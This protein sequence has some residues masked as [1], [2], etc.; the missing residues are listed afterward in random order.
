MAL[1][2]NE[3]RDLMWI[4]V[5]DFLAPHLREQ[6]IQNARNGAIATFAVLKDGKWYERGS[7]GWW[8]C[9]ADEKNKEE[10]YN[11]FSS[12]IDSL[13]DDTLLTIVDCHI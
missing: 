13:P 11:E 7:M 6:H 12:L 10:W 8:G 5:G 3:N 9:V 4:E 2:N 1:R